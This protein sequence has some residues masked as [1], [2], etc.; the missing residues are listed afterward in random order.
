MIKKRLG[1]IIIA[2]IFLL[3]LAIHN[4]ID[5]QTSLVRPSTRDTTTV[6]TWENLTQTWSDTTVSAEELFLREIS[7]KALAKEERR[8]E[9]TNDFLMVAVIYLLVDKFFIK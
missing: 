3:L 1:W 2:I 6:I 4:N 9:I 7:D 5:G 8:K